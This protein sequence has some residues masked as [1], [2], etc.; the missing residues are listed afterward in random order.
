MWETNIG[1]LLLVMLGK[2]TGHCKHI[3]IEP[4]PSPWTRS[5]HWVMMLLVAL[6][7]HGTKTPKDSAALTLHI[8]KR[9]LESEVLADPV[10]RLCVGPVTAPSSPGPPEGTSCFPL[11]AM[12][13]A[14]AVAETE[15]TLCLTELS[16]HPTPGTRQKP[17]NA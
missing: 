17:P 11:A 15:S 10:P 13:E 16:S 2:K 9:K 14:A 7:D 12:S 4:H 1:L 3:T 5:F 8:T 6:S